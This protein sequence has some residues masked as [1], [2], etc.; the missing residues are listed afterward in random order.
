MGKNKHEK[1]E[2]EEKEQVEL[3]EDG[4]FS[5]GGPDNYVTK[6]EMRKELLNRIS[7]V[8]GDQ[9]IA[10]AALYRLYE[11]QEDLDEERDKE[12]DQ[13][14]HQYRVKAEDNL[15]KLRKIVGG[16]HIENSLLDKIDILTKEEKEK[17]GK[18][19]TVPDYWPTVIKNSSF[20]SL[21]DKAEFPAIDSITD[22]VISFTPTAKQLHIEIHFGENSIFTDNV[23]KTTLTENEDDKISQKYDSPHYKSHYV[24]PETGLLNIF[25]EL[26]E[27]ELDGLYEYWFNF[28]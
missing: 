26:P 1:E 4:D 2:V 5:E 11:K 14:K 21:I 20:A 27:E 7:A 24:K 22:V 28:Y 15:N 23:L 19:V 9:K 8:Q 3:D 12:I 18:G 13:I 16:H 6:E 25:G 10:M 17:G